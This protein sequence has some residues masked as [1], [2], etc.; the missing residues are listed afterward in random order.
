M[1]VVKWQYVLLPGGRQA[2]CRI[3]F[4]EVRAGNLLLPVVF[5]ACEGEGGG[6]H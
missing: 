5:Q 1:V 3:A 6:G 2:E 4:V